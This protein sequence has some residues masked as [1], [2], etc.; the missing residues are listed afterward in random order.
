MHRALAIAVG[1]LLLTAVATTTHGA[2]TC[3]PTKPDILGPFYKPNAPVR[4]TVGT[5]HVL[6]GMVKSAGTCAPIAGAR[7]EFWL[8]A[9]T[10]QYDDAHRATVFS[11]RAGSYRFES[12][13]PVPYSGRPPHI[14]IRVSAT[15][16]QTL[17]T[18][19]YP[20]QGEREVTFAL[21]IVPGQ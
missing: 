20:A 7:V 18:Q 12:N 16:Y 17:V 14:H 4:S 5:G 6:T 3:A 9:P 10:G 1:V 8:V 15:G 2:A 13:F 21:V 11:D 19:Y